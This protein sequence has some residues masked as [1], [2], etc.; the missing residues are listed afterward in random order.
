VKLALVLLALEFV[1]I[2]AYLAGFDAG[3]SR[4]EPREGP[5]GD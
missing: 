5:L 1:A 4:V 2:Y 3:S